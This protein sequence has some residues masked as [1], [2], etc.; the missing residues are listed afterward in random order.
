[1]SARTLTAHGSFVIESKTTLWR[2]LRR[3]LEGTQFA[4]FMNCSIVKSPSESRYHKL[5]EV[6]PITDIHIKI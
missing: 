5:C 6:F 4:A 3:R 1:M 2:G